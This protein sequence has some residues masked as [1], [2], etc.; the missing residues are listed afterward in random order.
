MGFLTNFGNTISYNDSEKEREIIK[1]HAKNYV[2]LWDVNGKLEMKKHDD[3][4]KEEYFHPMFGYECEV[5]NIFL[6]HKEKKVQINLNGEVI[7]MKHEIEPKKS[8]FTYQ[9]EYG[10]WMVEGK[11]AYLFI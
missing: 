5:H 8:N 1:N 10:R 2:L 3:N 9:L 11:I 6:N 4:F 7:S